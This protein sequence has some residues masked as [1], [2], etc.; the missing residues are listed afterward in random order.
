MFSAGLLL[1]MLSKPHCTKALQGQMWPTAANTDKV[2]MQ[3][4]ARS[5]T[6][7]MCMSA[8]WGYKWQRLTINIHAAKR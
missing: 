5:G 7:E 3:T 4:L 1:V 2:A 6:L 8:T